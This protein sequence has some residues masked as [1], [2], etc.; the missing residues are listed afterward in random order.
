MN[1]E[2]QNTN[3]ENTIDWKV[4]FQLGVV[5]VIGALALYLKGKIVILDNEV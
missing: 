3:V 2:K 5:T 4:G 1:K